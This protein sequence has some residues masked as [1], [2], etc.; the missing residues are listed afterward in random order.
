MN[1]GISEECMKAI[2][3][4]ILRANEIREKSYNSKTGRYTKTWYMAVEELEISD[5]RQKMLL[6]CLLQGGFS[7]V[8]EI[9]QEFA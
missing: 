4:A 1:V 6:V 2:A 7:E 8:Y 5:E 9:A 3:G